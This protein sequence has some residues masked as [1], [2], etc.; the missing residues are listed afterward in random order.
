MCVCECD[1]KYIN[2]YVFNYYI[3]L[4]QSPASVCTKLTV[5]DMKTDNL[6]KFDLVKL[7][8]AAWEEKSVR[9]KLP[10]SVSIV[11]YLRM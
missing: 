8:D 11:T 10:H 7:L 4:S 2:A 9:R 3:F 6:P 5:C 1:M